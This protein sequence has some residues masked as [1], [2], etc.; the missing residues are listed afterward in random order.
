LKDIKKLDQ[1]TDNE[2]AEE[3]IKKMIAKY[4]KAEFQESFGAYLKRLQQ[5]LPEPFL[6]QVTVDLVAKQYLPSEEELV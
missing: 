5:Q 2:E 4:N 6:K 3:N 1:Q